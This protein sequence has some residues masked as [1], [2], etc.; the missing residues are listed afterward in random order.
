[1]K[2]LGNAIRTN[3]HLT[4]Q[5]TVYV[6]VV[7]WRLKRVSGHGFL[8][9]CDSFML[10]LLWARICSA[11]G[12]V[13]HAGTPS[14]TICRDKHAGY[15]T[16]EWHATSE[17]HRTIHGGGAP[18]VPALTLAACVVKPLLHEIL[19]YCHLTSCI[20]P[21]GNTFSWSWSVKFPSHGGSR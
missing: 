4:V 11:S 1:M 2:E 12:T 6:C 10:A 8:P 21:A 18:Q 20:N 19:Q 7:A 16:T 14:C 13:T 17:R 15:R 5:M 9:S 3:P